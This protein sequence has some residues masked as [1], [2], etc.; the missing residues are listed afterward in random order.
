MVL[1]GVF[2]ACVS[3]SLT[4]CSGL[5]RPSRCPG[6]EGMP[7]AR[8][9]QIEATVDRSDPGPSDAYTGVLPLWRAAYLD[10]NGVYHGAARLGVP[11]QPVSAASVRGGL[12]T[13]HEIPH[14]F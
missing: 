10:A 5:K 13:L 8:I 14:G 11:V 2:M 7:C 6:A 1:S 9:D 3:G 4:G 12:G